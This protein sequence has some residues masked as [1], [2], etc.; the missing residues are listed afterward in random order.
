MS[1][2]ILVVDDEESILSAIREYF[3]PLGYEVD[4]ARELE[5]AEALLAHVRY[6]LLIADLRLT[7]SQSA[8]GLE[9]VRFARERSPWT[10]IILLTG[11][12]SVEVETEAL[13]RGVDAFLQKPQPLAHLAD[14]ASEL[15]RAGA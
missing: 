8:E 7:G 9:L 11:Y 14:I 6:A 15:M 13:G 5:E 10:R 2:R 4:C 12:G 1:A 3:G